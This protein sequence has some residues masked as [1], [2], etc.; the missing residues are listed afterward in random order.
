MERKV[1]I[2]YASADAK[3]AQQ[4]CDYLEQEGIRCWIAPRDVTPGRDYA[5]EIIEGLLECPVLVLVLSEHANDSIYVK[6]EVE[7]AVS[8]GKP[9]LPIRVR[10]VM[11]SRSLELF[12]ASSHWIDAWQPPIHQYLGRLVQAIKGALGQE[13]PG[14]PEANPPGTPPSPPPSR[15]RSARLAMILSVT[16]MLALAGG[17]W[18]WYS[19]TQVPESSPLL[20]EAEKDT[21]SPATPRDTVDGAPEPTIAEPSDSASEDITKQ[22][23]ES[24]AGEAGEQSNGEAEVPTQHQAEP[25]EAETVSEFMALLEGLG[26]SR[27][28]RAIQ[29]FFDHIPDRLTTEQVLTIIGDSSYRLRLLESLVDRLPGTLSLDEVL[30]ILE[31]TSGTERYNTVGVI[32]PRLPETLSTEQVLTIIGDSTYRLRLLESL[33]DRLPATLTLDEALSILQPTSGTERYNTIRLIGPL[34]VNDLNMEEVM[35]LVGNSTYRD[36]AISLI[37]Q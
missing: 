31:P 15:R 33:V 26:G 14:R 3:I 18:W 2:S 35:Q 8:A 28:Y 23:A 27:R 22:G 11:P 5:A 6:R 12:V 19:G 9:V 24:V 34:L 13:G 32:Q 16:G 30:S 37:R 10:E 1:F 20:P 21:A 25:D 4:I 17:S 29:N 36:R 7:R